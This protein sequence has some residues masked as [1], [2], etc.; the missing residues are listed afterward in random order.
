M[1]KQILICRK[2]AMEKFDIPITPITSLQTIPE[3]L[4]G[5]EASLADSDLMMPPPIPVAHA[6]LP[7]CAITKPL[8]EHTTHVLT[9]I[10]SSFR[11]L[12]DKLS[13]DEGREVIGNYIDPASAERMLSFLGV[14]LRQ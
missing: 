4:Q 13:T 14:Q 8:S 2:R 7:Y 6:L 5:F 10:T 9:D 12:V 3:V 11:D 1:A